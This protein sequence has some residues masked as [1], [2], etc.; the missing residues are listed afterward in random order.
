MQAPPQEPETELQQKIAEPP[1][2]VKAA[3]VP[4]RVPFLERRGTRIVAAS[5]LGIGSIG[6]CVVL[7]FYIKVAHFID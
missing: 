3:H 2:I 7:F 6:A 1:E 4:F 5:I